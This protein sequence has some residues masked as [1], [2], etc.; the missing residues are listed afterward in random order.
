MA[1]H[2]VPSVHAGTYGHGSFGYQGDPPGT[3][4]TLW[5]CGVWIVNGHLQTSSPGSIGNTSITCMHRTRQ[6][7]RECRN[8]RAYQQTGAGTLAPTGQR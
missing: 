7:A 2:T 4:M 1:Q 6:Q 8:R 5:H 3:T